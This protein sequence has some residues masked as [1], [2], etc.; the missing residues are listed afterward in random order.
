MRCRLKPWKAAGFRGQRSEV[1]E[2]E[3]LRDFV[4]AASCRPLSAMVH[5]E[6][7][8]RSGGR[9]PPLQCRLAWRG[10]LSCGFVG[11]KHYNLS[12]I[13]LTISRGIF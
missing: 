13:F 10:V 8:A 3:G 12:N 11:L 6:Q 9:M 7:F 5:V 1:R 2:T 4:G